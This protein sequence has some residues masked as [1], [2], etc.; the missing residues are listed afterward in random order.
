M[1]LSGRD[2]ITARSPLWKREIFTL[3]SSLNTFFFS[4]KQLFWQHKHCAAQLYKVHA[5][6]Q[7]KR[8]RHHGFGQDHV[9]S[10][11]LTGSPGMQPVPSLFWSKAGL[12][13]LFSIDPQPV[14]SLQLRFVCTTIKYGLHCMLGTQRT[15]ER[16][17][18]RNKPCEVVLF[19]VPF[20]QCQPWA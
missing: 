14:L 13:F 10:S 5:L 7:G 3:Q 20:L 4:L 15:L 9:V 18:W 17:G 8:K 16:E 1:A 11:K 6:S 19:S 12:L 2:D